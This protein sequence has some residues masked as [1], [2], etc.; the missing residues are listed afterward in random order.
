MFF[1]EIV[2]LFEPAYLT[3]K[4]LVTAGRQQEQNIAGWEVTLTFNQEGGEK[5]AELT[6]SLAGTGRL[7][8]I[9]LD[10]TSISEATVGEQFKAAGITG[11]AATISGNFNAETARD[12]EVQ[13][14]GGSLPLPVKTLE[15]RTIGPTLVLENMFLSMMM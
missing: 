14:R 15:V 4:D 13:L 1:F 2:D 3:G 12:L 8:G 11:G 7:L 5:F 10:G 6:K 9:V